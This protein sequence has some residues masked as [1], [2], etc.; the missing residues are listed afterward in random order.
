MALSFIGAAAAK[1]ARQVRM[2]AT[3]MVDTVFREVSKES[4]VI[5]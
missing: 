4:V 1:T 5:N 3:C 2:I